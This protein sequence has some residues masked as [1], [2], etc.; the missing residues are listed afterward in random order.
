M[1]RTRLRKPSLSQYYKEARP[2]DPVF[3]T[4]PANGTPPESKHPIAEHDQT[5]EVSPRSS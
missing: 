1:E 4:P 2:V 5:R 3:L